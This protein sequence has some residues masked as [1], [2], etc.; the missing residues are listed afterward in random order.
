M[1]I[2][3]ASDHPRAPTLVDVIASSAAR[4]LPSW[5]LTFD[6]ARLDASALIDG[7]RG[8]RPQPCRTEHLGLRSPPP[9]R[10]VDPLAFLLPTPLV[11]PY[12]RSR[13]D[14]SMLGRALRGGHPP[15]VVPALGQPRRAAPRLSGSA[16]SARPL[17]VVDVA[18]ANPSG[19][20]TTL[21]L[22][23]PDGQP[24][25]FLPGQ[26]FTLLVEVG[27][28]TVR[29][30][31]SAASS[32]RQRR[33]V[34]LVVKRVDGG[35]VSNH[36]GDQLRPGA[37]IPVLGPSGSFT[38]EPDPDA[39]RH[40][41][42][43]GGGSGITPLMAIALAVLED[44]PDSDVTL[45]YGNRSPDEVIFEAELAQLADEH[46]RFTLRQVLEQPPEGWE[47]GRGRLD[48]DGV[49]A[50]IARLG[51][52]AAAVEGLYYLCG[53]EPMMAAAREALADAGVAEEQMKEERF[54]QPHL[55][56][57]GAERPDEP[58]EVA[59]RGRD[60]AP[61]RFTVSPH[62]SILDAGLAA[63][64]PMSFS[65]AMG[66]CGE[67]KCHLAAGEVGMEEPNCLTEGEREA[68]EVLT[69]V[70]WPVEP[71]ELEAL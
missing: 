45:I 35:L 12:Q 21:V 15:A 37:I 13:R 30:A 28:A 10:S 1:P 71:V 6:Q 17:R 51:L 59:F 66:G 14:L 53:P 2:S 43:I 44:E 63:G 33:S 68:G 5:A 22:E 26:F 38:C 58:I 32:W 55:R 36:I 4:L 7:L 18:P 31:Y 24:I 52:P 20:A 54:T 3:S 65:C 61:W 8:R 64:A 19:S 27:G 60:G 62:E 48:R 29:R 67:C 16:A 23:D 49:E 70:G 69:C 46:E 56:G 41:V 11:E 57:A 34:R 39:R 40:H 9:L 42:L 50:E 47:G 25:D